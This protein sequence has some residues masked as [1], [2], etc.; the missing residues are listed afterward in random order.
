[1]NTVFLIYLFIFVNSAYSAKVIVIGAGAA[2]I[3]AAVHLNSFGFQTKIIEA[4][5]RIGG[6]IDTNFDLFGYPI[7]LGAVHITKQSDNPI[8]SLAK[9]YKVKSVPVDFEN[10]IYFSEKGK[11]LG[12]IIPAVLSIFNKYIG[13]LKKNSE[14]LRNHTI[15]YS[16]LKFTKNFTFFNKILS[17]YVANFLNMSLKRPLYDVID[18]LLNGTAGFNVNVEIP[19]DGYIRI[20]KPLIN[21]LDIQFNTI[22]KSIKQDKSSISVADANDNSY[23]ADYVIITV[24]LGYLKKNLIKFEPELS[25]EKQISI[26]KLAFFNMNKLFVEFNEKFW[27]DEHFISFLTNP[28]IV[29]DIACNVHRI[30]GKNL[31]M[32]LV[33]ED[34]YSH[35]KDKSDTEIKEMLME[36][37]SRSYPNSL[38]QITKF[39][40]TNWN[41]DPFSYGS[42]TEV[43]GHQYLRRNFI[44]PEGRLIFA[45]EHTSLKNNALVY[46][47]YLSGIRAANQ[48][49]YLF[50]KHRK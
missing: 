22:I 47:A 49:N 36:I 28:P 34:S 25:K 32:F 42:F 10:I 30:N 2:G 50:S 45:G 31:L 39:L 41:D 1:M 37:I 6:R 23:T 5:N 3:S 7:D 48:I 27:G 14:E 26:E 24:P 15:E 40:K 13:F 4:R 33:S 44:S 18:H 43:A 21:S 35:I 29:F 9:R 19:P 38:I 12:N 20:L 16:F 8:V 11:N 46:G 17:F